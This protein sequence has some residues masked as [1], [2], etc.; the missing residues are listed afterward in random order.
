M[1]IQTIRREKDCYARQWVLNAKC[2]SQKV[3][4]A[5]GARRDEGRKSSWRKW[6]LIWILKGEGTLPRKEVRRVFQEQGLVWVK[7]EER[8]VREWQPIWGGCNWRER[9][10]LVEDGAGDAGR[11]QGPVGLWSTG[12]D[13]LIFLEKYTEAQEDKGTWLRSH[14]F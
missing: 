7:Q 9:W 2:V 1:R 8:C 14:D 13:N 11:T 12:N 3:L 10:E 4:V 5:F 6:S